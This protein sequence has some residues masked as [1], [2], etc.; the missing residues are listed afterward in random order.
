MGK[1]KI[2]KSVDEQQWFCAICQECHVED[3]VMCIKCNQWVHDLCINGGDMEK[4]VC[5]YCLNG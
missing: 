3:M 2:A 1:S 5:D 4:F